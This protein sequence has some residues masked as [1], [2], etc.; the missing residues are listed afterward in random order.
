MPGL[1]W[2]SHQVVAADGLVGENGVALRTPVLR[3]DEGRLLLPSGVDS[4]TVVPRQMLSAAEVGELLDGGAWISV[5]PMRAKQ[6]HIIVLRG[7]PFAAACRM[8]Q[9]AED[10][11]FVDR[12]GS[13][14]IAYVE[15]S[16]AASWRAR[17]A[18]RFARRAE[19]SIGEHLAFFHL[20]SSLANAQTLLELALFVT[21]RGTST[22]GHLFVL[23]GVVASERALSSW[24]ML[25]AT[26]L[27]ES[28]DL[29]RARLDEQIE[30]A[31]RELAAR[32]R[33]EGG[34]AWAI[35]AGQHLEPAGL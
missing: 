9:L 13:V 35:E 2:S 16:V 5:Q 15:R 7:A 32:A 11:Q 8:V 21:N 29:D 26:A 23:L 28:P 19:K 4:E 18:E 17:C 3:D 25:Q 6:G 12:H 30:D 24:P 27:F 31:R 22:R 33:R 10:L 20:P 1:S 34:S 14:D